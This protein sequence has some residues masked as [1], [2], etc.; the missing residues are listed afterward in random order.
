MD[1]NTYDWQGWRIADNPYGKEFDLKARQRMI[2]GSRMLLPLIKKHWELLGDVLLEAG[3]FFN[4]L[5]TVKDFP[6]KK[7]VYWDNDPHVLSYL[8]E[9][10]KGEDISIV[11]CDLNKMPTFP[12]HHMFDAAVASHILNYIEY[13]SFLEEINKLLN[14]GGLLFINNS[15]EYGLSPFFSAH[16]PK[17]NGE[18]LRTLQR[19]GFEILEQEEIESPDRA[20]QP[21][22][23]FL[24]VA[25]KP[26]FPTA[27]P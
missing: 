2:E 3:P 22:N 10:N 25:Q 4:P 27:N 6:G 8:S 9:K 15:I 19:A 17:S 1:T 18:L 26:L 23:R 24:I 5:L 12:R 16:R 21:H 13:A 14:R 7:I 11:F 20:H